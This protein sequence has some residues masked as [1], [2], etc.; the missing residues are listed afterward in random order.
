MYDLLI[1]GGR[2]F[3]PGQKIDARL[4]VAIRGGRIAALQPDIPAREAKRTVEVRG[5]NRYVVPGLIDVHTHVAFGAQTPGVNWQAADPE[6]AGVHSGVTTVVDCGSTGAYNFGLFPTHILPRAKTRILCFLNIGSHGLLYM[7][8]H[9]ADVPRLEDVDREAI[10]GCVE[11][12]PGLVNG[13]KLR[14]VGDLVQECGEELV[15]LAEALAREHH[16][17]LMVHIGE[18]L[19]E[20]ANA[21]AVTRYLLKTLQPL[22]ILTH[23]CTHHSG[24]VMDDDLQPV[25]ELREA[26]ANGVVLD[27]ASGRSN[28]SIDVARRQADLGLHPDTISTDM[29]TPGRSEVVHSLME[30]MAKFMAVGCSLEDVVRMTTVN[31]AR[32]LSKQ[33]E[34]GAIAVGREA[35]LSV[36]DV[37][38]GRWKYADCRKEAFSGDHAIVPVQTVRAG[39]LFAPDWGPYPWGWLPEEAA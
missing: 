4:D 24:G 10:A 34:L 17:P 32:A 2:V 23:L 1:K 38:P 6:L 14:L 39:E 25:P 33:D 5:D 31:A 11:A 29:S 30:C 15:R 8:K 27:P 12:N 35:D 22:D 28:F 26:R 9:R 18:V 19:H 13:I 37:L 21:P 36:M 3:D 16:L 7:H 20:S